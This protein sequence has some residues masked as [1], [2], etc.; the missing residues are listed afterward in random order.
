MKI[1]KKIFLLS[2]IF[3]A[4]ACKSDDDGNQFLLNN[5]NLAGSHDLVYFNGNI[6]TT[7]E[8]QGIP[9]T[10]ITT[11]EGDTFQ[12]VAIFNQDGTYSIDGQY[13]LTI[14]TTAGGN[15]ETDTEIIDI[16]NGTGTYQIDAD[17]QTITIASDLDEF[18]G[19]FDVTL[20]NETQVRLVQEESSI[21]EGASVDS[22][23]EIRFVRQ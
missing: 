13:R 19:T 11:I 4:F 21:V 10:A 20:F 8:I 15:T 14:T 1:F 5:E 9:V 16:D 23:I 17:E 22:I 7:I 2:F 6:E 3:L 12:V 18:N